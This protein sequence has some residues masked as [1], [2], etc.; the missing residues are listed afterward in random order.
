MAFV[1]NN[2]NNSNILIPKIE[3]YMQTV[4]I[5]LVTVKFL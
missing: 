5:K 1:K 2:N 4:S 3:Y